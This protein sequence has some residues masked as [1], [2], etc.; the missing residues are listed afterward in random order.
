MLKLENANLIINGHQ[1]L[2]SSVQIL[3][4]KCS[5]LIPKTHLDVFRKD[6]TEGHFIL[7][8]KATG[9]YT[10]NTDGSINPIQE[11]CYLDDIES[12]EIFEDVY[13]YDN[14]FEFRVFGKN[15]LADKVISREMKLSILLN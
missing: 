10:H 4:N 7:F 1:H 15:R 13:R 14:F 2:Y 12:T 8:R 3:P 5:F 9:T 11:W 6:L